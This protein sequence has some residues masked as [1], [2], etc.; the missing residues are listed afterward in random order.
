MIRVA[1]VEGDDQIRQLRDLLNEYIAFLRNLQKDEVDLKT[2]PSLQNV[3]DELAALPDIFAPPRGRFL[4]A[5]DGEWVIGCLA[6]KPISASSAEVKRMYVKPEY[7]GQRIGSRLVEALIAV[8]R[9]IGYAKLVLDS[10]YSMKHAHSV[11]QNAGF[12]VVPP[13]DD[14]PNPLKVGAIFMELD[15]ADTAD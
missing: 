5:L 8:A 12:R 15:L 4:V 13:P 1:Q 7:R 10:H 2:L 14:A 6:L 11:Y 3:D 9:E